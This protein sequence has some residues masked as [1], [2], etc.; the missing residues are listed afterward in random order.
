MVQTNVWLCVCVCVL[1][2]DSAQDMSDFNWDDYLEETGAASVPHHA[3]KHVSFP[4]PSHHL[5]KHLGQVRY[6][7]L[8]SIWKCD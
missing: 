4:F 3:F 7:S 1:D 2:G 6:L 8:R 5:P